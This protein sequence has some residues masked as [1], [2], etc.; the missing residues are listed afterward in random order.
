MRSA[1]SF[2]S[3]LAALFLVVV[4]AALLLPVLSTRL[5]LD[6]G[7]EHDARE[8]AARRVLLASALLEGA[9]GAGDRESLE[10]ALSSVRERIGVDMVFIPADEARGR[11]DL[12]GA[13]LAGGAA[14]SDRQDGRGGRETVR[15][16]KAVRLE[17]GP[18]VLLLAESVT[19]PADRSN[20]MWGNIVLAV[21]G[22]FLV[23]TPLCLYLTRHLTRSIESMASVAEAIGRGE[24]ERR[25]RVTP[26]REFDAL[27]EAINRM[28]A[29]AQAQLATIGTQKSQLEAV[30]DSMREGVMVLDEEGRI[31]S[32]NR[33]LGD[34]FPGIGRQ[35]GK[36]PIEAIMDSGLQRACDKAL[37]GEGG[38][39][40]LQIEPDRDHVYDVSVVSPTERGHGLGAVV[41]FHDISRLTQL[42]RVRRDFVANVSHELRTPLTSIKG[43]AET[44]LHQGGKADP[45]T[46]AR[47]L[48]IILKNANHMGKIV[49]DLLSL[50]RLEAGQQ[51][52]NFA[53]V[54]AA[55]ALAGA[56]RECAALAEARSVRL[57]SLLP[58]EGVL[59]V[60]DYD[61]LTQV[62]RNL[63]ENAVRFSPSGED[64]TATFHMD[65]DLA[66]FGIA[67]KGP[68]VPKEDQK[69]IFE[70]FFRVERHHAKSPGSSGL[71]LAI[72]KHIVERHG[73]RIWVNSPVPGEDRGSLFYFG[74]PLSRRNEI[75]TIDGV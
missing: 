60:A 17:V 23:A 9:A 54:D 46:T 33:A 10:A 22:S 67:D 2:Q 3:R 7:I 61:R 70:R 47:F 58:R 13:A 44:L 11:A 31:V 15:A 19:A 32:V 40:V 57:T 30:L 68:G 39:T 27:V 34:I 56:Q 59:V 42:E 45:P 38:T 74:I 65:G 36:K 8:E 21:L 48:E 5:I 63:I 16:A 69:R 6:R 71:G 29:N 51:A 41:V 75:V 18:G 53:E 55:S 4:L 49:G 26:G 52:M 24:W 1:A 43:Y 12:V 66:V 25:I 62:F 37:H 20:R 35:M 28:A 50:S 64:V 73:G 72:S 14:E